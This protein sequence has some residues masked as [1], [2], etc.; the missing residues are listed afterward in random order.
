MKYDLVDKPK[1]QCHRIFID[2]KLAI[3]VII[4]AEKHR[5]INLEQD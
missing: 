2:E 3:K 1:K 4:I 5:Y